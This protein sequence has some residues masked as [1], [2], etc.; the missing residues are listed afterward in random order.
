VATRQMLRI[1]AD[2]ID[3]FARRIVGWRAS[4]TA[5]AKQSQLARIYRDASVQKTHFVEQRSRTAVNAARL[6]FGLAP[7]TP[8]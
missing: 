6:H 3:V 1:C 2:V 7:L 5:G 4:R 8:F